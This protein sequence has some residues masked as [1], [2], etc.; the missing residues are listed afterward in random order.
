MNVARMLEREDFKKRYKEGQTIS[1][2]EFI[3]PLIQGYDSVALKADVELG[4]QDQR[5]NLLVGRDL[6]KFYG[7]ELQCL[8]FLPLLEGTDGVEKM[9]KSY[10]NHIGITE[11]PR[12]MFEKILNIPDRL[13]S[14]YF[15]LLTRVEQTTYLNWIS[16]DP[17]E[18]KFRLGFE[19]TK[20]YHSDSE[21]L[22][23]EAHFKKASARDYDSTEFDAI[24]RPSEPESLAKF[25]STTTRLIGSSSEAR[26]LL[27]QGGVSM[28]SSSESIKLGPQHTTSDLTPGYVLRV[29]KKITRRIK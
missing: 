12:A 18:A 23:T 5:F 25:L 17:R 28:A 8:V 20:L 1:I 7:Q 21:A 22:E 27:D 13:M 2:H 26:R 15:E 6:Q 11:S 10:G 4:G 16:S 19:I 24:E 14:K 9:S 29:G 3:Y